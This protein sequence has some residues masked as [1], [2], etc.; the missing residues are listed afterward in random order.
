MNKYKKKELLKIVSSLEKINHMV[1]HNVNSKITVDFNVLAECQASAIVVGNALES[2]G[3]VYES[4]VKILEDYCENL[5]QMS[6]VLEDKHLCRKIAK[7]VHK[8]LI[9]ISNNIKHELPDDKIE[10]VFLPYKASMW[11]CLESV[12]KAASVDDRCD[13]YVVPIPYFDRNTDNSFGEM[14]YEGKQYPDYVPIIPWEEY[15]LS[16]RKPDV[17][18]FHNPYDQLN[19]VTSVPTQFYSSEL[20]KHTDMLVYIPYFVAIEDNVAAHFCTVPGVLYANKVVVQSERVRQTYIEELLKY[21]KKHNCM[22]VFGKAEEKIVALGSPKYDKVLSSKREDFEIPKEWKYMIEKPDGSRKKVVLYNTTID[23]MLNQPNMIQTIEQTISMF[24]DV[25]DIILL[26]RPHPL[27]KSTLV[28]MRRDLLGKYNEV[29]KKF[30][31]AGWG[32]FDDSA[33]LYRAITISDVYYGDWS[34]VA[35]LYGKTNKPIIMQTAG[36]KENDTNISSFFFSGMTYYNDSLYGVSFDRNV[37]LKANDKDGVFCYVGA[38]NKLT[39]RLCE[40]CV[41]AAIKNRLFFVPFMEDKLIIYDLEK[42]QYEEVSLCLKEELK[43]ENEGNFSNYCVYQN[44]LFLIPFGYRAILSYN[45][46][47][48]EIKHVALLD[49]I[50]SGKTEKQLFTDYEYLDESHLLLPSFSSNKVV[51][52]SLSD[53]KLTVQKLGE[54]GYQFCGIKNK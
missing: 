34:S 28:T 8:Q 47:T 42:Q 11:D 5:Y 51:L 16:E 2:H 52:F 41:I 12:W 4:I 50:F 17:I 23:A 9:Q 39:N 43:V 20:Q 31:E 25:D 33:E 36:N 35:E 48:K 7:K 40:Y 18:Y 19:I 32:I 24:K 53:S 54:K 3:E 26:W 10:I 13:T 1:I 38:L 49:E 22:G 14:H 21:E 45:L 37:I 30:K 46:D 15:D 27:L 29:E 44:Q 6:N